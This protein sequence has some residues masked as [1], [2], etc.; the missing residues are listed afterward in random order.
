MSRQLRDARPGDLCPAGRHPAGV[1]R[2]ARTGCRDC[3]NDEAL[4]DTVTVV[5]ATVPAADEQI[6][7]EALLSVV[8]G[9]RAIWFAQ[10]YRQI[11]AYLAEN[12]DGLT[13][14][15]ST[16]P[17]DVARLITQLRRLGRD[18]VVD[19]RCADCGRTCF[20]RDRRPDGLRI[21]GRCSGRRRY[22]KCGRCG[23]NRPIFRRLPTG[24][25]LCQPCHQTDPDTWEP[26]GRCG[27][28]A[29]I[30]ITVRGVRIGQ[31]CYLKPHERCSVCDLGRA[32]SPY[33]SG[34]ATCADCANQPARQMCPL[35]P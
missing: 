2:G 11:A 20:P 14:G 29:P 9:G 15:A 3:L 32:V 17:V 31:C 12:P 35:W 26:C 18:D 23:S 34:K 5:V 7:G 13:S 24:S 33:A 28:S 21:C 30:R 4:E 8:E 27:E 6:V 10:R 1:G 22:A 25:P 19:P 16:T